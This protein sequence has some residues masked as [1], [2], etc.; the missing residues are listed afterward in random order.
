MEKR[1][2]NEVVTFLTDLFADRVLLWKSPD[3]GSG[4]W[5]I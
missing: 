4:G 3:V 5:R 2:T 1:V